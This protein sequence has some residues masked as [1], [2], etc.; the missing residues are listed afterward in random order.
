MILKALYDYYHRCGD[1]PP[2]GFEYIEIGFLIVISKDGQFLRFEDRRNEDGKTAQ[3]FQ[4]KK[5]EERSSN[6]VAYYLYDNSTYVFGYS[7]DG[8]DARKYFDTFKAKV[9][10]IKA[11][12]PNNADLAALWAFYQHTPEEMQSAMQSDPLWKEVEKD[13]G[14]KKTV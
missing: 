10:E 12:A 11:T 5:S 7:K 14:K 6:V 8:K 9:E 4:V 3:S 1:L 2:F 13:L